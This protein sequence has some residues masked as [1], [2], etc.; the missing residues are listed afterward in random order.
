VKQKLKVAVL[1]D[2]SRAYDRDILTGFAN[3]N[4]IHDRFIF[5]S[6]SPKYIQGNNQAALVDRVIAWKPDGI[7]TREIDGFEQLL[8][9]DI[10]LIIA[11]HTCLYKDKINLWGS[12][13]AVGEAAADYFISKG[14]R[15]YAFLGFRNFQWSSERQAGY[16]ERLN[17]VGYYVNAHIFDD[18]TLLWEQLPARLTDWLPKL[19]RPCAVFSATDELNI[20]LL[21]AAKELGLKVPDDLSVLGVDNDAMI[22]DMASPTLSSIEHDARLAGFQAATALSRWIEFGEKP[23]A[24]IIA[25]DAKVITRNSTSALAVEDEQVRAAL[26]FIANESPSKEISVD[27]VVKATVV[28]R[29]VLEIKF[30]QMIKSSI[31]EEIKKARI[32]RIKFL[33]EDSDLTIQQIAA[34]MNFN[35]PDNITRYFRQSMGVSPREYRNRFK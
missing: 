34:E 33:L 8:D 6:F 29:R 13:K 12:N 10:P 20:H 28:S 22:C 18:R 17:N 30:Q 25:G 1:A 19:E 26:H 27:D 9:L 4:R 32:T 31:L 35:N 5:F 2:V 24:D 15:N 21:E 16:I 7:L 3:F 14:Y 23:A 11:P